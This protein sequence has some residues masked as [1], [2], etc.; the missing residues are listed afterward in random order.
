MDVIVWSNSY[1]AND[2]T[3]PVIGL[4]SEFHKDMKTKSS[5]VC[6]VSDCNGHGR[7]RTQ[8]EDQGT[9]DAFG[10]PQK[11]IRTIDRRE[12]LIALY[13]SCLPDIMGTLGKYL[14]IRYTSERMVFARH[15]VV[16]FSKPN[17]LSQQLCRAKLQEHQKEAI[18]RK[19]CEGNRCQL[20]TAFVSASCVTSSCNGRTFH[21]RKQDTNYNTKWAVNVI[22]CDV[23][24]MQYAGQTN[25]T[26][27]HMNG[28]KSHNR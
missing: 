1:P 28:H 22:I 21:C 6:L 12:Y 15:P 5:Q 20:C 8:L 13:H 19:P 4:I 14:R 16:S 3:T 7:R 18:Q 26:R 17:N 11:H 2:M 23:C 9:I 25:N 27:S 24:G 10:E